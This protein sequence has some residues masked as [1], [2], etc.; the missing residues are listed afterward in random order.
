MST[1]LLKRSSYNWSNCNISRV[2][3]DHSFAQKFK[4]YL[5]EVSG[6][7]YHKIPHLIV[8]IYIIK[9][10]VKFLPFVFSL[11]L[12]TELNNIMEYFYKNC[13]CSF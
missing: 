3:N 8:Y 1:I 7:M 6:L 5:V 11:I 2:E 10:M 13:V 4:N 9:I 12:C